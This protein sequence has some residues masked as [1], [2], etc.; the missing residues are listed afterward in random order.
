MYL[1]NQQIAAGWK[2]HSMHTHTFHALFSIHVVSCAKVMLRGF[3]CQNTGSRKPRAP[4][5]AP[6]SW[7]RSWCWRLQLEQLKSSSCTKGGLAA[8][9][10]LT[11]L[12]G[13][14]KS[15]GVE[16]DD[17][18][19]VSLIKIQPWRRTHGKI[20]SSINSN[21]TQGTDCLAFSAS[22][23][24]HAWLLP[25]AQ[26]PSLGPVLVRFAWCPTWMGGYYLYHFWGSGVRKGLQVFAVVYSVFRN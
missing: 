15:L 16:V 12:S 11:F 17:K 23:S 9:A 14:L 26:Q 7:D 20:I 18:V 8:K 6:G 5:I 4:W 19:A 22:V 10:H 2:S 1:Q 3:L 24:W 25:V 21:N 13:P